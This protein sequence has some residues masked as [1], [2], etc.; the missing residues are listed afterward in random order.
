M[1]SIWFTALKEVVQL[2]IDAQTVIALRLTKIAGG[3]SAASKEARLMLT[4][5]VAAGA[6][7]WPRS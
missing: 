7:H 2:G 4:E 5:K 3:G 6:K 1:L